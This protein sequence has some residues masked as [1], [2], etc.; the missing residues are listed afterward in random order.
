MADAQMTTYPAPLLQAILDLAGR[1][2]AEVFV[3]GG[4]VRDWLTGR[5]PR[6]LDLAVSR[7]ALQFAAAL[8]RELGGTCVLLDE[9]EKTARVVWRGFEIDIA[10]FRRGATTIREDLVLR[11]FTVNALALPFSPQMMAAPDRLLL[12][13]PAGG[14]ADLDA[15]II[16]ALGPLCLVDDPL[17]LLRAFRFFAETGFVIE[18]HTRRWITQYRTLLHGVSPERLSHELDG[19]MASDR[20]F[21]AMGLLREAGLL[22]ELFPELERGAG[23]SQPASHHLDVLAHNLEALRWME[24][25]VAQPGDFYA[26]HGE[27]L[28]GYL[29]GGSR[30]LWLKWAALLHDLGKP[31]TRRVSGGRITFYHHERLGAEL[32]AGLAKRLRWSREKQERIIAFVALH[33]WPF[34][35]SNVRR[36]RGAVTGRACLK[37]YKAAAGELPGLFLLAMADSLA[38]RGPEKPAGMERELAALYDQV[39]EICRKQVAPVLAGPRLVTGRDLIA[40]GLSPGPV[41]KDILAAVEKAQ[42]EGTVAD[43]GQALELARRFLAAH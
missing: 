16:R 4:T 39:L 40:M 31:A 36:K 5:A 11:D 10:G 26:G 18:A 30:V 6:D 38:G 32:L 35:L 41:F 13:D 20:A 19:I 23:V 25:I 24:R 9:E 28:A 22:A 37:M 3:V 43:R 15:G 7:A 29:A 33:M 12:I 27:E 2:G 42:V 17:R 21:R 1:F 34:H 8:A 14:L